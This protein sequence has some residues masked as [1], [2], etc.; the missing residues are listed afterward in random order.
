MV[1]QWAVGIV[2]CGFM[3][4]WDGAAS[5]CDVGSADRADAK[6]GSV[7]ARSGCGACEPMAG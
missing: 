3:I 1:A 4:P 7:V 6:F 2:A 5:V